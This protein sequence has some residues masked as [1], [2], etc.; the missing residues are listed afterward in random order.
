MEEQRMI[1]NTDIKELYQNINISNKNKYGEV[2]TPNELI[3][4]MLNNFPKS[5]WTKPNYK[6]LDPCAGTGNFSLFIFHNLM[7]GLKKFEPNEAKRAEH[8]V[9]N[10]LYMI[11]LNPKN[12]R[13]IKFIFGGNANIF[14]GSFLDLIWTKKMNITEFDVILGNPPW[15]DTKDDER[16]GTN[17][18]AKTLYDKFVIYSLD[19]LKPNGYMG[20]IHP[21]NWRGLGRYHHIWELLS[22]KQML[23]LHIYGKKQ[24]FAIFDINSRFDLYILQNR[25]NTKKT[26]IIDENGVK[27]DMNISD[28]PFLPNYAYSQF[29]KIFTTEDNGI[30]VIHDNFY[31]TH[32]TNKIM[33]ATKH[34]QFKYPVIHTITKKGVG[35]YYTSD[36]RL[37]H[38]G[39]P[40]VILS[41]NEKQ[42]SHDVQNDYNGKLGMSQICFGIP[43]KSES[44]GK[45]IMEAVETPLF[46]M[47]IDSTKWS[48][49]QT[50]YRMFKY[51]R[52]DFYEFF[53]K[54]Q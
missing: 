9:K 16:S 32:K 23:Y 27:N 41:F 46:K 53:L 13:I 19:F 45:K 21:A 37:G 42:Y 24:G 7:S 35:L 15:N 48:L 4:E 2:F 52:P 6:W 34:G 43:I 11:E 44:E 47:L 39:Q 29:Q 25:S 51:L 20:F 3:V 38:F 36:N 30:N 17:S 26:K 14:I 18:G 12:A 31:S 40:K 50:D 8:I 22:K 28:I 54:N 33:S 5:V 1:L 49:Y 10:M